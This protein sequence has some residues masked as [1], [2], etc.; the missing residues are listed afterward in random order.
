MITSAEILNAKIL[1]V[2]DKEPDVLL[3]A[4]ILRVDGYTSVSSTTDPDEVCELH[5]KNRYALILLDLEMPRMTGFEVMECLKELETDGYLPVPVFAARGERHSCAV[6]REG[7][8]WPIL[9]E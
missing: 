9:G 1:I 5:R 4:S 8:C 3:L 7:H 6:P 2:D